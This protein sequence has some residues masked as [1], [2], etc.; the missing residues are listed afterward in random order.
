MIGIE[1]HL[2]ASIPR[3]AALCQPVTCAEGLELVNSMIEGTQAQL[4]LM[5]W[6]KNDL[7]NMP[8]D[9][10]FG[11]LGHRYRQNCCRRNADVITL[12]K[13]VQFNSKRDDLCRLNNFADKYDGVYNKLVESGA[14]E[15]LGHAVWR[16]THNIIVQAEAEAYGRKMRYSLLHP[17]KLVFVD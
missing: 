2:L 6:K 9:D 11:T 5:E 15:K 12:K 3:R 17:E 14:A 1:A 13:Y 10:T 7:K 4:V 16:H 8:N